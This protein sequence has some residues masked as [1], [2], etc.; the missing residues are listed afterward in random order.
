[1]D[2]LQRSYGGKM[3]RPTPEVL[4]HDD[5]T[6]G[7]I[8]TPWGPKQAAGRAIEILQDFI[9]SARQDHEATSPF[10]KLSCL[11]PLANNLRVAIMLV[12]DTLYREDNKSEYLSGIEV[13]VFA[14]SNGELAYAQVGSPHL[15]LARRGLPLIPLS[16]QM[17]LSTEMSKR[18]NLL[19]PLPQNLIG[20]HTTSN[21]NIASF[22]VQPKDKLIFLSHS[23]VSLPHMTNTPNA[24]VDFD[25][26]SESLAK[27]YA[28][29]PFWLGLVDIA[30]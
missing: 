15:I 13:L 14:Q 30:A 5:L 24:P 4:I 27:T 10:Q 2:I 12:N 1:M 22:K 7:A 16:V 17:D 6:F 26:I 19:S 29:L 3:F 23:L 20:L 9:L 18:S 8:V 11:S 21:M 25:R 28:D